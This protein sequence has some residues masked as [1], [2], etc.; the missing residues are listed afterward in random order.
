MI[1]ESPNS[2][3]VWRE[4]LCPYW[5]NDVELVTHL[6]SRYSSLGQKEAFCY[7][8]PHT[9]IDGLERILHLI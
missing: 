3:P 8:V 9:K 1:L 7:Y 6:F 4:T 2:T 5:G